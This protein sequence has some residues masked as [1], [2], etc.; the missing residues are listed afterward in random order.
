MKPF[1]L[2]VVFSVVLLFGCQSNSTL[3]VNSNLVIGPKAK[4]YLH[5]DSFQVSPLS[6]G[7]LRVGLTFHTQSKHDLRV[8]FVW[9]DGNG[10]E[11]PGLATR[12]ETLTLNPNEPRSIDRVAPS[13][14]ALDYRIYLF[15]INST[16]H[17]PA[18]KGVR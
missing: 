14:L 18:T 3:P 5:V 15:D 13:P 4:R 17:K 12:W 10:F 9:L 2:S 7:L 6:A 8:R 11:L 16:A 1:K